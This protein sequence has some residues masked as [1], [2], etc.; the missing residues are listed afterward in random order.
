MAEATV[1]LIVNGSQADRDALDAVKKAGV[2]Y[3]LVGPLGNE[4][5]PL[6]VEGHNVHVGLTR[7]KEF[8]LAQG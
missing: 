8:L 3:S 7:I 4:Q 5:T 6:L 1:K 2:E